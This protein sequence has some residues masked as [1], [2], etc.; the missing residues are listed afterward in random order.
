MWMYTFVQ[1]PVGS[2]SLDFSG[3]CGN[4]GIRRGPVR[5]GR[6]H[7]ARRRDGIEG[8]WPAT[9][10]VGERQGGRHS[11]VSAGRCAHLQHQHRAC[12]RRYG[13]SGTRSG[14]LRT[15]RWRLPHCRFQRIEAAGST[16]AFV[17]PAGS[18]TGKLPA[19]GPRQRRALRVDLGD[20]SGDELTVQVT[21][22][23]AA[24][25]FIF[26]DQTSLPQSLQ[27]MPLDT[28]EARS[29]V[30]EIRRA[31]AVRHG[32]WRPRQGRLPESGERRRL[33]FCVPRP[34][35]QRQTFK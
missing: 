2:G 6:G 17:D 21:L 27:H 15:A 3:N 20:A 10:K 14:P 5:G 4:H 23:D 29:W 24:N 35:E 26:V 8:A 9:L 33:P 18:M 22:M 34:L 7:G 13:G 32:A 31:G 12:H 28:P 19:D 11:D 25:P 30:E 16:S 1:V